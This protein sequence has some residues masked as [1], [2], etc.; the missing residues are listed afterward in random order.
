V[1]AHPIADNRV[2][3]LF[4]PL[5]EKYAETTARKITHYGRY[6]YLVFQNGKNREKGI[7]PPGRSPLVYDWNQRVAE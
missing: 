1:F 6:S 7:W 2:A 5:S 4:W 3:A